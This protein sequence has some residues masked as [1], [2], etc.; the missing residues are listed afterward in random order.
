MIEPRA[1]KTSRQGSIA[2]VLC[3]VAAAVSAEGR[4][5]D[6]SLDALLPRLARVAELFRDSALKFACEETI[7][8]SGKEQ[9]GGRQKFGYVF[10]YSDTEGYK[11]YRTWL[12]GGKK[13]EVNPD[14]YH[15]PAYLRSAFVWVFVFKSPRQALH[16]Y[17]IV[18]EETVLDRPAVK[19]RFEP[20]LP[21][22]YKIND[23]FGWAWV[24]RETAQP[25][26]VEAYQPDD[27]AAKIALETDLGGG[28]REALYGPVVEDEGYEI[29]KFTTEFSV[30]K[31]GMRF[32]GSVEIQRTRYKVYSNWRKRKYREKEIL[33]VRQVYRNYRFYGV[34]TA[35]EIQGLVR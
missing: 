22:R 12:R 21:Y 2:V 31:N 29:E 9:V 14:Q 8:W 1:A 27:W 5:G 6:V 10:V 28:R 7:T 23:W 15:V 16:R 33:R 13:R 20:I 11:D 24:D 26:K 30:V 32:P 18:G 17:E 34:R 3:L 35:E 19:I 25:L 4:S